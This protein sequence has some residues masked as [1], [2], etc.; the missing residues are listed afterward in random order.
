MTDTEEGR[1]SDA[2]QILESEELFLRVTHGDDTA[3]EHMQA[4]RTLTRQLAEAE[5]K[6]KRYDWLRDCNADQLALVMIRLVPGNDF[7][8]Y[9]ELLSGEALDKAI[10]AAIA[11]REKSNAD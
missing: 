10:D 6:A 4:V 9:D 5:Q 8:Y 11:A 1:V 2:I 7:G 3:N